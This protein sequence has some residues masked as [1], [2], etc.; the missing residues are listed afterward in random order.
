M[1]QP[2]QKK[3]SK[4][5]VK[6]RIKDVLSS[7]PSSKVSLA[8]TFS[9]Q[10]YLSTG[11]RQLDTLLKGGLEIGKVSEWGMPIGHS[12]RYLF[13]DLIR[14]ISLDH[15]Q[16]PVLWALGQPGIKAFA[17][18]W[19]AFGVDLSRV[20]FSNTFKPVD[21]LREMFLEP[22]F[23]FILLDSPKTLS[24]E[25]FAF[26]SKQASKFSFHVC[27][28]QNYFLSQKIGNIWTKTRVNCSK[29]AMLPGELE[30]EILRGG[31]L[32]KEVMSL[33]SLNNEVH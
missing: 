2:K 31:A 30:I 33:F 10:R 16:S 8:E 4:A 11:H 1:F 32:K 17:S 7:A 19:S 28:L 21:D 25:E 3:T 26:M 18:T 13:V 23:S 20:L 22:A 29:A 9:T 5:R 6:E 15:S 27:I 14:R 24:K 12:S